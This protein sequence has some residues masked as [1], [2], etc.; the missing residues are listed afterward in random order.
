MLTDPTCSLATATAAFKSTLEA[1]IGPVD[2]FHAETDTG[3]PYIGFTKG[4]SLVISVKPYAAGW[5]VLIE[6]GHA[7]AEVISY[8][9][10]PVEAMDRAEF[11]DP[12]L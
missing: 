4:G 5:A 1:T 9:A 2:P 7:E 11:A 12:S 3:M 6:D 10:T 8:A